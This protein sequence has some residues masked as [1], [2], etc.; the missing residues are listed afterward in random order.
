[1]LENVKVFARRRRRIQ[2]YDNTWTFSLKTAKLKK[3]NWFKETIF[4][5]NKKFERYNFIL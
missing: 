1:M 5:Q 2:G 4:I 3:P